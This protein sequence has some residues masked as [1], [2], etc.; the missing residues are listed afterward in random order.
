[1]G[2]ERG[3]ERG[4]EDGGRVRGREQEEGK[5]RGK[6]REEGTETLTTAPLDSSPSGGSDRGQTRKGVGKE[7]VEEV[8]EVGEEDVRLGEKTE[9]QQAPW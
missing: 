4:R 9:R 1:M 8:G 2:G 3:K 7:E 5:G 6:G